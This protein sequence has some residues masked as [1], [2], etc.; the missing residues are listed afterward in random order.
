VI[1]L[2]YAAL[3]VLSLTPWVSSTE[4]LFAGIAMGLFF[5][6][7][8]A[9]QTRTWSQ[10]LL[11]LSII[12]LGAGMNLSVIGQVG[13]HGILYTAIGISVTLLAGRWIG[14]WMG[15]SDGVC[16]LISV[17]T[18]ICGGSA[19]A[20]VAPVLK[21]KHQDVSIALAVVFIL[22]AFALLLFP[23]IGHWLNLSQS[24]FGLWG[25]LAIHDTSSVVGATLQY[26]EEALRIG[27]TVKLAR[28]LWIIPVTL[29]FAWNFKKSNIETSPQ[30]KPWFILG[31]LTAAALVTWVPS[32]AS[33]GHEV[34]WLARRSL[35]L[36]LFLI[37][38]SLS[39]KSVA[40][41]GLAPLIQGVLLWWV[42]GSATLVAITAGW[43]AL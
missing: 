36:T 37:G 20:A 2:A 30:K 19:I 22:N 7:P 29:G 35:V 11:Q 27:T 34:E 25:A 12:G 40:D 43:I 13:L 21:S 3:A 5:G 26:G 32:L 18:A 14:R 24:Q 8:W 23:T 16:T 15:C 10:K 41:L 17:G 31:F 1:Q 38:S 4:A 39:R 33:A 9:T 6:N 28:A 42:V